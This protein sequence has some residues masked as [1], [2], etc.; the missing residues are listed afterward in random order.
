MRCAVVLIGLCATLL[1]A[2]AAPAS[3]SGLPAQLLNYDIAVVNA[4][5]SSSRDLV[6]TPLVDEVAATWSPDGS[7]IAY[8]T[9]AG[10]ASEIFIMRSD[11]TS[12]HRLTRNGVLDCCPVWSP[13]GRSIAFYSVPELGGAEGDVMTMGADG[14]GRRNLTSRSTSDFQPRWSPDGTRIAFVSSTGPNA[15]ILVMNADGSGKVNLTRNPARDSNPVWAPDS[16]KIAFESRGRTSALP[17]IAVVNADGSGQINLTPDGVGQQLR[18]AWSPDGTRIVFQGYG[19]YGNND[20]YVMD[21]DGSDKTNLTRDNPWG[22]DGFPTWSPDGRRIAYSRHYTTPSG[23]RLGRE[24]FVMSSNG[25]EK[26]DL[27]NNPVFDDFPTWSPDGTRIL[28]TR[29]SG[30]CVVPFVIGRSLAVAKEQIR[31]WR[32]SVG[33]VMYRRSRYKRGIVLKTSPRAGKRL[34]FRSRVGLVVS[35]GR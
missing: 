29:R 33:R 16:S 21:A 14:R 18:P 32:C 8:S 23:R 5:G 34:M 7:R 3:R 12:K 26:R 20:I 17:D 19:Y 2:A 25:S 24:V 13:D 27:T 22:G 15:E 10:S 4:D 31:F 1:A 35:Q 30:I 28:F 11:G 6:R 9:D